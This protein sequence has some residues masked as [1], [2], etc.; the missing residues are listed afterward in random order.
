[1]KVKEKHKNFQLTFFV[2]I[3]KNTDIISAL[4]L[5][6][7]L[8]LGTLWQDCNHLFFPAVALLLLFV[9]CYTH[10]MEFPFVTL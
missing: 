8:E 9:L 4:S 6:V 10:K 5:R 3:A 1:M 2:L 7:D